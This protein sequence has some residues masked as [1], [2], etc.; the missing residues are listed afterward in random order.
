M[1]LGMQFQEQILYLLRTEP[2]TA[3]RGS[4]GYGWRGLVGLD[5]TRKNFSLLPRYVG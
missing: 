3:C 2:G 5:G 1:L 4:Q